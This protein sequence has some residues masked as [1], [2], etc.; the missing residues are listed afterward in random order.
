MF[1]T[2]LIANR[3]E[4]A[5]RII[6][7]A[8]RMGLRCVS[9][10]SDA[11]AEAPHVRE[12]D[13]AVRIGP[14]AAEASYLNIDAILEAAAETGADAVHPGYGFLS[15][16]ADFA[17][18]C[19]EAGITF[20]GPSPE[21]IRAMGRKDEAKRVMERAGVPVVPGWAGEDQSDRRLLKSAQE[22][23]FPV[24]LKAVAGGGGKGL[25][26]VDDADAFALALAGV[27]REARG[28][29]GDDRVLV[30]KLVENPRHIEVQVF[31][32]SHGNVVHF[33]ERDCSL[34]RR[35]QKVIEEAPAPGLTEEAR[36]TLCEAA[37]Q[38]AKAVDYVNAGTVEF[39][40]AAEDVPRGEGFYFIEMNTRLQV[41][42][43]VTEMVTGVDLVEL[44]LKVAAGEALPAQSDIRLGGHAIEARIYAE[45]PAA[46]FRPS[47]GPV[48]RLD[49]DPPRRAASLA[50]LRWD[51]GLEPGGEVSDHY[52]ATI[53][54]LIAW[55]A[56]REAAAD[57]LQEA[58]ERTR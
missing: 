28:A 32:D 29:F 22:I 12:S 1:S 14:A 50:R 17:A 41:E 15:E 27:R 51:G 34:Q 35:H 49:I 53:G 36:E 13:V 56:T 3:G 4:I 38:A 40:A 20:V 57:A 2:L 9:V 58:L 8:G 47:V 19:A 44:Q 31:G 33:F 37:V 16:N 45:D 10:Y 23:G 55:A 46:G 30:E 39:V 26:R 21:A 24:L 43:P 6:R 52:D 25:R 7:T 48:S 18:A 5:R 11:D 54:K 42:H